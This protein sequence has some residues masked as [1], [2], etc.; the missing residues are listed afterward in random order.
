MSR[1]CL[2]VNGQ[3]VSKWKN[4]PYNFYQSTNKIG[5]VL[6]YTRNNIIKFSG[7][8]GGEFKTNLLGFKLNK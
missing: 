1:Y 7:K 4:Q 2:S 5:I 6:A 8:R 3:L